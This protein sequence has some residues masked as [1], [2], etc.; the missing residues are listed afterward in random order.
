MPVQV[1]GGLGMA[2]SSEVC[3][4]SWRKIQAPQGCLFLARLFT[5]FPHQPNAAMFSA[6]VPAGADFPNYPPRGDL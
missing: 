6:G 4:L 5:A 3:A 2:A 1:I